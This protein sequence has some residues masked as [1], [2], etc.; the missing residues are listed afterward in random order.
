M[1]QNPSLVKITMIIV[2]ITS[3]IAPFTG[4]AVNLGIPQIGLEYGVDQSG[5]N[6]VV[7]SY[8]LASAAFL[9][10]FGRLGDIIG[11]K[12]V[13]LMGMFFFAVTSL[14]C[15][16]AFSFPVLIIFRVLQGIASAMIFGTS[17]A[18]L[19]S[20]VPPKERGRA[21]GLSAA[22]TYIGL[23]LGPVLGGVICST[24]SWRGIFYFNF[25]IALLVFGLT[26]AKLSG[27]WVGADNEQFDTKGSV[28]WTFGI[29]LFL[30]GLSDISEGSQYTAAFITGIVLLTAFVLY[31]NKTSFPLLPVRMFSE[32]RAF[33]FSN[34]AALINYSATFALIYLMSIYLQ[35][36]Q[37]ID[38]SQSGL[39]LLSQPIIMA[40]LSPLAGRL[41]DKINSKIL[42]SLGI[43][44]TTIGLFLFIFLT[45]V[46][47]ITFIIINLAFIGLGFAL[48]SSPNTNAVMS[49]VERPLYGVASSTLAT[50]RLIGQTLSM[51][52]VALITSF[53]MKSLTL[54]SPYYVESFLR[55]SRTSF[56]V[57]TILCFIGVFASLARGH[58]A[59]ITRHNVK[60]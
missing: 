38:T 11:R 49:S 59:S 56:I 1:D 27:E 47:S 13:F 21:M 26:L 55:S 4:N 36:V 6:W 43:G 10:P 46:T 34:L 18:I 22:T 41:S 32:N 2:M 52:I 14:G 3:F 16:L 19:T 25:L 24:I 23:S 15:G 12:K 50:M 60:P 29:L 57:F 35:N 40:V 33:S 58:K 37:K 7:T 8:L 45:E 44:I 53:D 54:D 17:M 9:L 30:Y 5:L 20:V 39:I 28:F 51:T 31:E 48:F 42:A